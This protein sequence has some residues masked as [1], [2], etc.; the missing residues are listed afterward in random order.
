MPGQNRDSE[1]ARA[2]WNPHVGNVYVTPIF[3]RI[4]LIENLSTYHDILYTKRNANIPRIHMQNNAKNSCY[5]NTT[6]T[7][8]IGVISSSAQYRQH[9]S[10]PGM[11]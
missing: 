11:V 10:A 2:Y 1:I 8:N 6:F 7:D 4:P 5:G 9:L 3:S